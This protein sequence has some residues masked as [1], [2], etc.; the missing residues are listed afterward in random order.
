VDGQF[1]IVFGIALTAAVASPLGGA[2][3]IFARPS[4]LFLSLAVGLAAGVLLGT[5][6]FEML[7]KA[8]ELAPL[9]AAVAGFAVGFALVYGLDLYVNR[10]ALAGGKAEQ[11]ERVELFHR[12]HRPRGSQVTVLAGATSVEELIEGLTIGVGAA[13]DP[14]V[15][16]VIG[17]AICIDNISEALSIGELAREENKERYGWRIVKWTGLIGLSLFASAMAGW[18]LLRGLPQGMLGFLLATGAGGMFYLTVTDLIPEAESHQYQ[19]SAAI[20][21]GSGFIAILILTEFM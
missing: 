6:A 2:I 4:S 16:F 9:A 15:A 17:A 13:I 8:L 12:R 19:Q 20:S 1:L 14:S 10:G 7:P 5:F 21:V 3:A 18:F 11:K